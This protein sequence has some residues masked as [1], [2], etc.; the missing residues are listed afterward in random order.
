[1]SPHFPVTWSTETQSFRHSVGPN[2]FQN[3]NSSDVGSV[4]PCIYQI[5]HIYHP[6]KGLRPYPLR[7]QFKVSVLSP[8]IQVC[9]NTIKKLLVLGQY[10]ISN[11]R[12]R[13]M[14]LFKVPPTQILSRPTACPSSDF[15]RTHGT[16]TRTKYSTWYYSVSH[17]SHCFSCLHFNSN[18]TR[19]QRSCFV[20]HA[21]SGRALLVVGKWIHFNFSKMEVE[22]IHTLH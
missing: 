12:H 3:L 8:W 17:F 7:Q 5:W 2:V 20:Q 19:R 21:A 11:C 18:Y 13:I 10:Q 9:P 14:E 1:M 6:W 4:K 22:L 16:Q 15:W